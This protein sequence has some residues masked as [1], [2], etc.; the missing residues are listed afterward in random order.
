MQTYPMHN[1]VLD[2]IKDAMTSRFQTPSLIIGVYYHL[3]TS[4]SSPFATLTLPPVLWGLHPQTPPASI[5]LSTSVMH[6]SNC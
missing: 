3:E 6:S 2:N 4:L 1:P 5:S